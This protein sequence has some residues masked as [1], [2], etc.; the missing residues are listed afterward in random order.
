MCGIEKYTPKINVT[1]FDE[2]NKW[3]WEI[4]IEEYYTK[5]DNFDTKKQAIRNLMDALDSLG[6]ESSAV[7][8]A[9][10]L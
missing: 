10:F 9:R 3:T 6:F 4:G 1:V 7:S 2:S 8:L 5:G